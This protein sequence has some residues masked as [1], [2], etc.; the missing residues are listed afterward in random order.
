MSNLAW[1]I[2]LFFALFIDG[3]LSLGFMVG[4]YYWGPRN[5]PPSKK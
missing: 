4:K 2:I 1:F 5:A 3:L